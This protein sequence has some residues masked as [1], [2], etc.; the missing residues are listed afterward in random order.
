MNATHWFLALCGLLIL[1][2]IYCA[3]K[4]DRRTRLA[5]AWEAELRADFD[6][7]RAEPIEL[8]DEEAL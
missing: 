2:A 3:V 1:S 6:R 7:L 4:V 5:D 8:L